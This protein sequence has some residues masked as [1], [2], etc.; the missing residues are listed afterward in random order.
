[1][2]PNLLTQ[3]SVYSPLLRMPVSNTGLA[4]TPSPPAVSSSFL[5]ENILRGGGPAAAAFLARPVA[6]QACS[7]CSS[8]AGCGG[9][10]SEGSAKSQGGKCSNGDGPTQPYLKFGVS[11]ILAEEEKKKTVSVA[12]Q[13]NYFLSFLIKFVPTGIILI[14]YFIEYRVYI[15]KI[16]NRKPL[17]V[18]LYDNYLTLS[19]IKFYITLYITYKHTQTQIYI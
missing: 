16:H 10:S 19:I 1:M 14:E 2:Y 11:A 8:C 17:Y 6:V 5:V 3:T 15:P 13:W 18:I 7:A 9:C 4:S 12:G